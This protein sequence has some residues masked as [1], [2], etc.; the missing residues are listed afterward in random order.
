MAFDDHQHKH[1]A[2]AE[3]HSEIARYENRPT[4]SYGMHHLWQLKYIKKI[5]V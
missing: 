1:D 2:I 3:E 4:P 5:I